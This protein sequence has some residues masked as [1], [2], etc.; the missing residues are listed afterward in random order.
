MPQ[1][2]TAEWLKQLLCWHRWVFI[3]NV[4]WF[5]S[6]GMYSNKLYECPKCKKLKYFNYDRQ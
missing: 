2:Q 1:Q 6:E 3:L 5:V 4:Q